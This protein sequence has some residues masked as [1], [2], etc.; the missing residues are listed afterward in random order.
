M[1]PRASS[2][3]VVRTRGRRA[4]RR[5]RPPRTSSANTIPSGS[6]ETSLPVAATSVVPLIRARARSA[7]NASDVPVL[8]RARSRRRRPGTR[9]RAARTRRP[10]RA[11]AI[12]RRR[13][14]PSCTRSRPRSTRRTSSLRSGTIATRRS[15][16][17]SASRMAAVVNRDTERRRR[18]DAALGH[19]TSDHDGHAVRECADRREQRPR[20]L[21]RSRAAA[22]WSSLSSDASSHRGER[23]RDGFA[24]LGPRRDDPQP[25]RTHAVCLAE[26]TNADAVARQCVGDRGRV[27]ARARTGSGRWCSRGRPRRGS[28]RIA[29]ASHALSACIR[30]RVSSAQSHER[31]AAS[32][33]SHVDARQSPRLLA[34]DQPPQACADRGTTRRPHGPPRSRRTSMSTAGRRCC[35]RRSR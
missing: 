20:R 7:S 28:T 33:T 23:V 13:S 26:R 12:G 15:F 21:D 5:R 25:T 27:A 17:S 30:A 3:C 14:T 10:S 11:A 32:A 6:I 22:V 19:L 29:S 24:F 4:G 31:T 2:R 18:R 8:A 35:R 34:A 1:R 16:S 9:R